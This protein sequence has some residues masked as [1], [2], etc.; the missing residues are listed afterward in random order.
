MHDRTGKEEQ[1]SEAGTEPELNIGK[2]LV[3]V[4]NLG[5]ISAREALSSNLHEVASS[6]V[7]MH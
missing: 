2:I 1:D 3:L 4:P 6:L 5:Q 7:H